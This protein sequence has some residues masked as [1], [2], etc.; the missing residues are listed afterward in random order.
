MFDAPRTMAPTRARA[1]RTHALLDQPLGEIRRRRRRGV[2]GRLHPRLRRNLGGREQAGHRP[3]REPVLVEGVEQR[4]LVF[5]EV[6]VVRER[7]ALQ[8]REQPGGLAD[9]SA[10][11]ARV[12][13]AM[14]G[15]FF[16]GNI[17]DPCFRPR[18]GAGTR[19]PPST[20]A[21]S[22]RRGATGAPDSTSRRTTPRPRSRGPTPRRVSCRT[23]TG[24]PEGRGGVVRVERQ[25]RARERGRCR[26]ATRR[27]GSKRR[28]SD[29]RRGEG[30]EVCEEVV[31]GSTG[32]VRWRWV[33]PGSEA[34]PA[35]TAQSRRTTC[36]AWTNAATSRPSWAYEQPHRGR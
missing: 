16:C 22:P 20:T 24:E 35:A 8:R 18:Q 32:C 15:F 23:V 36:R 5:L 17:D 19:I 33:Y 12:S 14:S 3:Q 9:Q 30:P 21:R 13:L 10:G 4:L 28:A 25:A 1:S 7:E 34:S 31:R 6:P 29:R 2:G 27:P 11:L 26:A